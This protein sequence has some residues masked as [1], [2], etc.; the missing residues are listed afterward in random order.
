MGNKTEH[1]FDELS[2]RIIGVAIEVHK[3]LGPGFIESIYHNA[4]KK[5][6]T[7]QNIPFETEKEI[8]IVYKDDEIGEHRLDLVINN[9]IIVELKAVKEIA[10]VHLAQVLSYL[11]ASG[12]H[13]GL[14][15]NFSKSKI[16][17]KRVVLD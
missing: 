16:D 17:I 11:K 14:I 5:E 2:N 9:E 6:L 4:M 13:I 15:L 10:D 12:L 7:L 8:K 1:K 3:I